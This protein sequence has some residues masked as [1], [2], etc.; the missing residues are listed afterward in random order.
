VH[1][2][3]SKSRFAVETPRPRKA[4]GVPASYQEKMSKAGSEMKKVES[5]AD[6]KL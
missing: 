6:V 4:S 5:F 1:P 3:S 2:S